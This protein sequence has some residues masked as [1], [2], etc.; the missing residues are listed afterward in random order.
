MLI[1][2]LQLLTVCAL[3]AAGAVLRDGAMTR[4]VDAQSYEDVY[5]LPPPEWLAVFS[6]GHREAAA[7]LVWMK[8][9]V[10]I[11]NE[12]KDRG[13]VENIYPYAR[14][15]LHLDPEFR[16]VYPWVAV[17]GLYR[18]QEIELEQMWPAVD[19]LEEGVR[20]FPDDGEMAYELGAT[21]LYEI[22]PRVEDE[23]EREALRQRATDHLVT[24]NRLGAGPDWLVLNAASELRRLGHLE[25]AA[26]HL[27]EMYAVV[28]DEDARLRIAEEIAELRS[29]SES[30]RIER[31]QRTFV[32]HWQRDFPWVPQ[33]FYV[34]L[35]E[36]PPVDVQATRKARW[37]D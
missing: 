11:G 33:E 12:F 7:D 3:L 5:Y 13:D 9:L 20:R 23:T 8:A 31:A 22:L 18:P 21:L 30:Q 35:G 27:E 16:D 37:L 14:A 25:Q 4:F 34:H 24:A 29:R 19:I 2:S 6:L 28:D 36:R 10:Y 15:I 1:R 26:R 17:V 32:E